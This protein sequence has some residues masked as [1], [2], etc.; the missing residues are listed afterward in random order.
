MVFQL[1]VGGDWKLASGGSE[2]WAAL[3]A[4]ER[5]KGQGR[6]DGEGG[7]HGTGIKSKILNQ[8]ID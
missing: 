6:E 2:R 4:I 7:W 1:R 3:R 8:S 5:A